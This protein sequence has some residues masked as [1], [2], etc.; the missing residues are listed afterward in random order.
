MVDGIAVHIKTALIANWLFK[1]N[2][3]AGLPQNVI[4]FPLSQTRVLHELDS[5]EGKQISKTM[6]HQCLKYERDEPLTSNKM[7]H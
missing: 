3:E 1:K 2:I 7:Y 6:A 4:F 5:E